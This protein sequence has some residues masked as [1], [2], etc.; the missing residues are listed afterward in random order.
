M[1][2]LSGVLAENNRLHEIVR[3]I[4]TFDDLMSAAR[5]EVVATITTAAVSSQCFAGEFMPSTGCR[6]MHGLLI[7]GNDTMGPGVLQWS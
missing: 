6:S 1:L 2:S 7:D 4:N 3:I 5:G